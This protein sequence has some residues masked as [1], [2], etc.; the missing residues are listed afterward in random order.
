MNY[1]PHNI[2]DF[3]NATRHLTRVERALYRDAIEL[4]YDTESVLT[5]DFE[6]L[7]RRLLVVTDEEK[8]ALKVILDE[9]FT[10][11]DEGYFHDRCDLEITKYRT[12][13]SSKARAGIASAL[14]RKGKTTGVKQVL[15]TCTTNEQLTNNQEPIT[16]YT[17]PIPIS[18]LKDFLK[19][20]KAKKVGELT[21]TAF[22]GIAKEAEK[23]NLTP[24]QAIEMCC[25]RGWAGF[26]A[27]WLSETDAPKKRGLVL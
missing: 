9:F 16:I 11:K 12:N 17:P 19:V 20:R 10:E 1:Y 3:N 8:I 21:E 6:K 5:K 2:G 15:N 22:N 23:V 25:S 7:S 14:A 27:S 4:Y 24:I 26:N 13:T 18:L